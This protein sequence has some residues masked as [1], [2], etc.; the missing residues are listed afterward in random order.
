[1]LSSVTTGQ[2]G[3]PSPETQRFSWASASPVRVNS[4]SVE[5]KANASNEIA[6]TAATR[7]ARCCKCEII[8]GVGDASIMAIVTSTTLGDCTHT[9]M[10]MLA[11]LA[12]SQGNIRPGSC[13]LIFVA[14]RIGRAWRHS[15][16]HRRRVAAAIRLRACPSLVGGMERAGLARSGQANSYPFVGKTAKTVSFCSILS[17]FVAGSPGGLCRLGGLARTDLGMGT[18]E[19]WQK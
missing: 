4:A 14:K 8:L 9:N 6:I 7:W 10:P 2:G 11:H 1:M 19:C 5:K 17:H 15:R 16:G 3:S 18:T 12:G 13:H